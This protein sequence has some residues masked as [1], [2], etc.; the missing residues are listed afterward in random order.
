MW[1][2]PSKE[3]LERVPKLYEQDGEGTAEKIVYMHFFVANCDWYITEYDRVD[4]FFGFAIL[5][6]PE[7]AEWGYISFMELKN[8]KVSWL[9]VDTD[10]HWQVRKVKEVPKI[11]MANG[12]W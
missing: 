5:G 4:T 10:K 8:L 6:D 3:E 2:K 11:V 7:M 9:E 12:S 1:A